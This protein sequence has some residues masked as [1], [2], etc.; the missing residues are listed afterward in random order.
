MSARS[1]KPLHPFPAR[2]AP[3]VGWNRLARAGSNL[4][5]LDPMAGAGTTP[6]TAQRLRH[7]AIA[8]DSDPLAVEIARARFYQVNEGGFVQVA[9]V[10]AQAAQDCQ[11][12]F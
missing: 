8:F 4:T 2:M 11:R 7:K 5:G 6:A 3:A 1:L 9:I 12:D 10:V